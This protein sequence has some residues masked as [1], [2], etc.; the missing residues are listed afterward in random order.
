MQLTTFSVRTRVSHGLRRA[1]AIDQLRLQSQVSKP[2][3]RNSEVSR[4]DFDAIAN[5]AKLLG[6]D[7]SRT[8]AQERVIDDLAGAAAI[9]DH[10]RDELHGL[11]G[12]MKVGDVWLVDFED[13]G[14]RAIIGEVVRAVLFPG[15]KDR[16]VLPVIITGSNH[17]LVLHPDQARLV[18]PASAPQIVDKDGQHPAGRHRGVQTNA[19]FGSALCG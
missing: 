10:P 19:G 3:D 11:R 7:K 14:L 12:W 9:S 17:E 2:L 4:V 1:L 6:R 8:R 5:P 13:A 16:F 15:I 18:G